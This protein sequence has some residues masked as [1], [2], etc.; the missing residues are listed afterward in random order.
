M[1]TNTDFSLQLQFD[2]DAELYDRARPHYPAELFNTIVSEGELVQN[3]EILEVGCGS[4]Q[5]TQDLGKRGFK[6]TAIEPGENLAEIA[7]RNCADLH[8]VEIITAFFEKWESGQQTH[9]DAIISANAWHWVDLDVS[10]HKAALLL[11]PGGILAVFWNFPEI[12]DKDVSLAIQ[13][14][15]DTIAPEAQGLACYNGIMQDVEALLQQ[16]Q[17]E[18]EASGQFA[19]VKTHRFKQPLHMTAQE[20][21]NWIGTYSNIQNLE[22]SVRDDLNSALKNYIEAG[23]D[24]SIVMRNEVVLRTASKMTF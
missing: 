2:K 8:Y 4:G 15:V 22:D 5:A 16:G 21:I 19:S 24:K 14:I 10:Y 1:R 11:K 18:F 17:K 20:F 7:R 9:F 12:E 3:S 23:E 13:E 6:V